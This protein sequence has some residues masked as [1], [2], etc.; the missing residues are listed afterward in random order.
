MA[1]PKWKTGYIQEDHPITVGA[2]VRGNYSEKEYRVE[3]S[4]D[5]EDGTWWIQAR[6]CDN[7]LG[8]AWFSFLGKREGAEIE[9]ND[10]RRPDDK[11]LVVSEKNSEVIKSLQLNFPF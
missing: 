10:E 3:F 5:A 9:I 8:T 6:D 7:S 11:L 4:G 2:I 1:Q